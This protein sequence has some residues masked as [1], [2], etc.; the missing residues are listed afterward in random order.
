MGGCRGCWR[1]ASVR[2][3]IC[4]V[5]AIILAG[6]VVAGLILPLDPTGFNLARAWEGPSLAHLCGRDGLGRDVLARLVVGTGTSLTI[7]V[8][9]VSVALAL[10]LGVGGIAGWCGSWIDAVIM[11]GVD[12]LMG[13][14]ELALAIVVAVLIGRSAV[15][16]VVI[17]GLGCFPPLVRFVRSLILVQRGQAHVLAATALGASPPHVLFRHIMPD[18]AGPLAVRSAAIIGPVVQAEAALSFLGIGVQDPSASLGTLVRDGLAGLRSGSHL[19]IAATVMVFLIVL[20]F[21]LLADEVRDAFDPRWGG[22][23][24]RANAS[25]FGR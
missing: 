21:S 4:V 8:A 17:L 23:R 13:I 16:V 3:L 5:L 18:I 9:S 7:G 12:L 22:R 25:V 11:R 2:S 6:M 10:A 15:A 14:R 19:I 1:L 20:T 24:A